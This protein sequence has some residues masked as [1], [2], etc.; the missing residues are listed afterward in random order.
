MAHRTLSVPGS[1]VGT[2]QIESLLDGTREII[3]VLAA[4]GALHF[5]NSTFQSA[6]GYVPEELLGRSLLALVHPVDLRLVRFSLD[7]AFAQPG[8]PVVARCRLRSLE[9]SWRW[10]E[11]TCRGQQ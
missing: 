1:A 4:D 9:G 10:F 11:V 3:G 8:A 7:R 6:L 2:S 5:A